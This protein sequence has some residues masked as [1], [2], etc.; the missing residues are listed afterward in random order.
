MLEKIAKFLLLFPPSPNSVGFLCDHAMLRAPQRSRI[1]FFIS[2]NPIS[3]P[4]CFK[5]QGTGGGMDGC[6]EVPFCIFWIDD[7]TKR[8]QN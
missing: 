6:S 4:T 8:Q 5:G 3:G 7:Q 2:Y 1:A